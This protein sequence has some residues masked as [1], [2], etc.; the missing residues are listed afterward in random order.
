MQLRDLNVGDKFYAKSH[1]LK[2]TAI[3]E[4]VDKNTGLKNKIRCK[5]LQTDALLHKMA[6]LEVIKK[7]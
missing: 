2:A 1:A 7:S 3:F 5:N 6:T 4:V